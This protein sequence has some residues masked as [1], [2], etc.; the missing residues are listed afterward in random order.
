MPNG[1]IKGNK[2]DWSEIY[3]FFKILTDRKLVGAG[4]NLAAIPEQTFDVLSVVRSEKEG[5]QIVTRTYNLTQPED[6]VEIAS[7]DTPGTTVVNL[8]KLKNAVR[9]IFTSIELAEGRSFNLSQAEA[10]MHELQCSK[11]KAS[12][13]DK[14]DIRLMIKD[15][16]TQGNVES[17]FS[18]KTAHCSPPTLLNT[19][20]QNTR[21]L[22]KVIRNTQEGGGEMVVGNRVRD[23]VSSV[24]DSG[25]LEFVKVESET[26]RENLHF[27]DGTFPLILATMLSLY[28]RGAA[29]TVVDLVAL[30]PDEP[31]LQNPKRNLA[32]YEHNVKEFLEAIALGMT[33]A[34]AWTGLPQANGGY[35]VVK[36]D[37]DLVCYHRADREHFLNYLYTHTRFDTPSTTRH[38]YGSIET[39]D[40]GEELLRLNI[41]IRFI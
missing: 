8:K 41:Q 3:A 38:E 14:T 24:Y 18:I 40:I 35:I 19:S 12:S 13:Q 7:S 22:Y 1:V 5:S 37:G 36:D 27:I 34:R 39:N 15:R 20:K 32:F 4:E 25:S 17:G 30:L 9:D 2:G 16:F 6:S 21:F 33:P 31:S 10:F 28:H 29:S 11:I 23:R 26:F